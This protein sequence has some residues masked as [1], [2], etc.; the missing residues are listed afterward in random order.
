[1]VNKVLVKET[2]NFIKKNFKMYF[3]Q[4]IIIL[5]GVGFFVGMRVSVVDLH[6]IMT[7]FIEEHCLYDYKVS[8]D[9]GIEQKDIEELKSKIHMDITVENG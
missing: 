1:M 7:C 2:F 6:K 5:L 8:V 9:C 4:I 3:S